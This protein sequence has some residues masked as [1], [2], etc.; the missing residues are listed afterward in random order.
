MNDINVCCLRF[1]V[2]E[3]LGGCNRCTLA[4]RVRGL[5]AVAVYWPIA[6]CA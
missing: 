4:G 1:F 3:A 2:A 5:L 6:L